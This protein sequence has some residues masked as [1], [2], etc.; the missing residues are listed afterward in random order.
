MLS[1]RSKCEINFVQRRKPETGIALA[2]DSSPGPLTTRIQTY[3]ES[4]RNCWSAAD[5]EKSVLDPLLEVSLIVSQ[6]CTFLQSLASGCN[7]RRVGY[8][9]GAIRADRHLPST[10]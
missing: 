7:V 6:V 10:F 2:N 4:R 9:E 5:H 3:F 1:Q 8:Q